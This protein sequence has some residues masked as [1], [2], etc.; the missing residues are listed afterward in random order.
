MFKIEVDSGYRIKKPKYI[1]KSEILIAKIFISAYKDLLSKDALIKRSAIVFF[2][3]KICDD[4]AELI[5]R[6]GDQAYEQAKKVLNGEIDL[7]AFQ[8]T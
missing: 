7:K 1:S 8:D 5:G 6:S 4:Y 2:S 3:H